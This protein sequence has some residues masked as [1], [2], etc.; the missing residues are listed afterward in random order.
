MEAAG[1]ARAGP[2]QEVRAPRGLGG[3][4][5]LSRARD[6]GASTNTSDGDEERERVL[7]GGALVNGCAGGEWV[8]EPL[9]R[10]R[11]RR[12]VESGVRKAIAG[13][14]G[15]ESV[16]RELHARVQVEGTSESDC[17]DEKPD[18]RAHC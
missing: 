10:T 2:T 6:P 5:R 14:L 9:H 13:L 1:R 3:G 18:E 12:A 17:G 11:M 16:A 7:P 15:D 8:D 4:S